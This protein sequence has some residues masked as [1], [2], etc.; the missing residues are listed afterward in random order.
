VR[1]FRHAT[2]RWH[3]EIPRGFGEPGTDAAASARRELDEEIGAEAAKLV[4]LGGVHVDTGGTTNRTELFAAPLTEVPGP[5]PPDAVAEGIDE[6]RLVTAAELAGMIA[7]GEISDSFTLAAY[8]RA[9]VLG[10]LSP[11]DPAARP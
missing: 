3:W 4:P 5:P 1:H 7:T 10:L 6:I 8:A 9:V 11:P 2:R